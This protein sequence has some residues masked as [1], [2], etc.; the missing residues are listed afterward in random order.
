MLKLKDSGCDSILVSEAAFFGLCRYVFEHK[1]KCP[2]DLFVIRYGK[3]KDDDIYGDVAAIN[4]IS[5]KSIMAEKVM[6][7]LFGGGPVH[8]ELDCEVIKIFPVPG[9]IT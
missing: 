3:N 1:I 9:K 4:V 2:E 6:S 7:T 8:S 5:D